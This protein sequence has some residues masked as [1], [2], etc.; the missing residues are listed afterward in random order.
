MNPELIDALI[1]MFSSISQSEQ[2]EYLVASSDTIHQALKQSGFTSDEINGAI[3][4]LEAFSIGNANQEKFQSQK[5]TSFRVLSPDEKSFLSDEAV[6]FLLTKQH[7]GEITNEQLEFILDQA[8]LISKH[9]IT[10]DKLSWIYYMT[11]LNLPDFSEQSDETNSETSD[12]DLFE[13]VPTYLNDTYL[14]IVH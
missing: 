14:Y 13:Q 2:S 12:D 7:Q 6:S 4:W 1:N 10:L 8:C 5:S 3:R 9:E 11:R